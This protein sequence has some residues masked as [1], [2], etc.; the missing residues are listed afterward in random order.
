MTVPKIEF[1]FRVTVSDVIQIVLILGVL[2]AGWWRFDA[3]ISRGED[4]QK[5]QTDTLSRVSTE[6]QENTDSL[7]IILEEFKAFPLHR[8][9]D[10]VIT[11]SDGHIESVPH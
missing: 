6:V 7:K 1:D 4:M 2:A 9:A 8:H 10:H 3:R 11:Y 5:Q